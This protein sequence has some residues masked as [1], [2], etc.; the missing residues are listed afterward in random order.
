MNKRGTASR[1]QRFSSLWQLSPISSLKFAALR[2]LGLQIGKIYQEYENLPF[3]ALQ[4]N[5]SLTL[6]LCMGYRPYY[7]GSTVRLGFFAQT[8]NGFML[9]AR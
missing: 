2:S 6:W 4:I 8:E 7:S 5:K 1:L 3:M 9:N